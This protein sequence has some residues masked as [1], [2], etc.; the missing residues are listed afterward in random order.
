[1]VGTKDTVQIR[2]RAI[3]LRDLACVLNGLGELLWNMRIHLLETIQANG[4][5]Q[6]DGIPLEMKVFACFIWL[7]F[8]VG[9]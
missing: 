1:L 4:V 9:L 5:F 8:P 7:G 6:R 2:I 3:G